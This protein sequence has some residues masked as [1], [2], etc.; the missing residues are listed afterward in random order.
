MAGLERLAQYM[1]RC[2]LSL[3]RMTRVTDED[4]VIYRAEK[5]ECR[6][7]PQAAA[8]RHPDMTD[9]FTSGEVLQ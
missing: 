8:A 4:S 3:A 6:R 9:V 1:A 5:V 7:F 2:P